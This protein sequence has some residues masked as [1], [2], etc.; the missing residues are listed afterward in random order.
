MNNK[1]LLTTAALVAAPLLLAGVAGPF[2]YGSIKTREAAP[3]KKAQGIATP[4]TPAGMQRA[5]GMA[6][7]G[8]E[9]VTKYG[10]LTT[11]IE[12]D[13]S[14]ITMGTEEEPDRS[15]A[16]DIPT[17]IVDPSNG[18]VIEN[19]DYQY[20]WNNMDTQYTHGDARWG[21]GNAYPAGGK[22]CFTYNKENPEAHVVTPMMDLTAHDGTFVLEFRA[23]AISESEIAPLVLQIE[24]SDTRN[25]GPTWDQFDDPVVFTGIPNGQ[26]VTYRVIFQNGGPTSICNIYGALTEPVECSLLVD[27]V[28]IYSLKPYV[29]T[30]VLDRHSDFTATSFKANWLPVESAEKYKLTVWYNDESGKRN[31]VLEDQETSDNFYTVSGCSENITYFYDVKAVAGD[32]ESLVQLPKEVFDIVAPELLPA[33]PGKDGITFLGRVNPVSS[34]YGYNYTAMSEREAEADGPF[35]ITEEHFTGWKHPNIETEQPEWTIENPYDKVS[36][37]YYPTDIKQ[38]GW[39]GENYMSYKDFLCLD[40]FFW[41]TGRQQCGWISPAFDLS[42]DGGKISIDMKLAAKECPLWNEDGSSAGTVFA[43]CLVALFNWNDEI[44]DYE[45]VES[46]LCSDVT[47][48]WKDFHVDLTKGTERSVIGFFAVGSLDNLYVDDIIIKQNYKKGEKFQDPFFYRTWQLA[49]E[50]KANGEDHTQFQFTVPDYA[51]GKE[52]YN[53]AQAVRMHLDA[54]GSYDGEAISLFSPSDYVGKTNAYVGVGL[55]VNEGNGTAYINN[56]VI[57]VQNPDGEQV[58]VYNVDGKKAITLGKGAELQY[59]AERGVYVVRI[60]N[61]SIKLSY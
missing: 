59:A 4:E 56:G 46:V 51:S 35:I 57:Y 15:V 19:P 14:L 58:Y 43:S 17:M 54:R 48:S 18:N 16:L 53:K 1:L 24:A 45:Q 47:G 5:I 8:I 10:E 55:V 49:E 13:F 6:G 37:L 39:Y 34:A 11:L 30:P 61:K 29:K 52:V 22:V 20:V 21:I 26:W 9:Q 33:V 25:W 23:K 50:K 36:T 27:D 28:K 32:K 60:G 12:E 7:G 41:E 38:Q 40:P 44:G 42:K 2:N 31:Y 3:V